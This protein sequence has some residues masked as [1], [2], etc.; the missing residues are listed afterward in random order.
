MFAHKGPIKSLNLE[1]LPQKDQGN[2]EPHSE[3]GVMSFY[4]KLFLQIS[5]YYEVRGDHSFVLLRGQKILQ[6]QFTNNLTKRR[7]CI[8]G[9]L[10][11][12]P[13]VPQFWS[14]PEVVL[15]DGALRNVHAAPLGP[16]VL[17][18][19][20]I[21]DEAVYQAAAHVQVGVLPVNVKRDILPLRVWQVHVLERYHV[22][23]AVHPVH[24]VQSV[25]P[26]VGHDLELAPA[27]G[28]LQSHQGA[29][30]GPVLA[31]A[32]REHKALVVLDLL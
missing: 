17:V 1:A 3:E 13:K 20:L 25:G 31:N 12:D 32:G 19:R 11:Q 23:R 16:Q 14:Y 30:R 18:E 29:P 8:L 21:Q 9:N 15:S 10:C 28:A 4:W 2:T 27:F 24:Q 22:L 5:L 7:S 26:S 6:G